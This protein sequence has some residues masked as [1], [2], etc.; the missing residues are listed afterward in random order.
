M[1]NY[2]YDDALVLVMNNSQSISDL[3]AL[4]AQCSNGESRLI[5][6]FDRR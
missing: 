2:T 1:L 3:K 4:I 6:D 5:Y